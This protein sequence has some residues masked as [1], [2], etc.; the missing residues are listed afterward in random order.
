MRTNMHPLSEWAEYFLQLSHMNSK[1]SV[2][3]FIVSLKNDQ[4]DQMDK[5]TYN[6]DI[7]VGKDF[8]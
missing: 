1:H 2:Q 7:I 6:F 5:K 4:S 8:N 3:F